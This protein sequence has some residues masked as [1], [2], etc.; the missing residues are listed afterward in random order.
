M[1]GGLEFQL[2]DK[3]THS[4]AEFHK[5]SQSFLAAQAERSEIQYATTSFN[6][7]FPQYLMTVNAVQCAEAGVSVSS[8]LSLM[9]GYYGSVYASNF[10]Q[11]VKQYRVIIRD[12]TNYRV[13]I[14]GLGKVQVRTGSNAM[15]PITEFVDMTC[16]YGPE[17]VALFNLY[18]SRAVQGSPNVGYSTGQAQSAI[19]ATAAE[20]LPPGYGYEFPGLS[21][22]EQ[23]SGT[24]A[25]Y[26][27]ALCIV[28][29]YQLLSAQYESCVLPFAV[30]LS[31]PVG[32]TGV[33]V[34]AK[35]FGIDNNICL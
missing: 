6:P 23:N 3:A 20:Y 5:V 11:F 9:R 31:L 34:F 1:N 25:I 29:V 8:V 30:L 13:N 2:P 35:I 27:F 18:S 33:C 28:F 7:T 10:N 19:T 15:S 17:S 32:L 24:R 26:V 22:E 12:D 21:C 14:A 4:T 16:V